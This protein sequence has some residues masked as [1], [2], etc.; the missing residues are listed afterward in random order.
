MWESCE[1]QLLHSGAAFQLR[2]L[3]LFVPE[4]CCSHV[5]VSCIWPLGITLDQHHY[6]K[7]VWPPVTLGCPG[8]CLAGPD[9]DLLTWFS[10]LTLDLPY[11]H[12]L[13]WWI[14][15]HCGPLA[16]HDYRHSTCFAHLAQV[17]WDSAPGNDVTACPCL[18]VP[19]WANHP[20]P[21][22]PLL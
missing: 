3:P 18:A 17:P 16:D 11:C 21:K 20:F 2:A 6:Y 15:G 4:L 5:Q 13:A 10:D 12:G 9:P 14:C 7:L 22:E 8:Y 19:L 1:K